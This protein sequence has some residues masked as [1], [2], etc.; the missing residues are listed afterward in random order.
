M[1]SWVYEHIE[2]KVGNTWKLQNLEI[3]N[4]KMGNL[5]KEI[6]DS[7]PCAWQ[8]WGK[9]LVLP[10]LVWEK[11]I[12]VVPL[13]LRL[14]GSSAISIRWLV[15]LP[16]SGSPAISTLRLVGHFHLLARRASRCSAEYVGASH[17]GAMPH[18]GLAT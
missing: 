12:K 15:G 16:L 4:L 7:V 5:K 2:R 9:G 11:P 17:P 14:F 13:F 10:Q 6:G 3:D 1:P 18:R 8:V